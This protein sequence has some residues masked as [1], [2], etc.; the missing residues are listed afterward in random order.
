[1]RR[2]GILACVAVALMGIV[3]GV[4]WTGLQASERWWPVTWLAWAPVGAVILWKRSGNGVGRTL[5]A[6]GTSWGLSFIGLTAAIM[7]SSAQVMAWGEFISDLLGVVPWLG[8]VWLLLV[9]PSGRVLGRL[10]KVTAVGVL[11][12]SAYAV[13]SFMTSSAPMDTT[14]L[15]S[16]LAVPTLDPVTSWLVSD[17][18]FVI[19]L[20]LAVAAIVSLVIRWWTS[21]GVERHQF[22]WLL[23]GSC[24]YIAVLAI[25]QVATEDN[26]LMFVWIAAGAAIPVSIGVAVLRYRLYD[27]DRIVSRTVAYAVVVILLGA[28]FALGVVGMPNLVI[29]T[30]SAPPLVVAASTLAVAALFNPLRRRVLRWVDRRFNRSRYDAERVMDQFALSLRDQ[31]DP[32]GVLEGW[33]G[34]VSAAMQPDS[35]GVWVKS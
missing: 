33:K 32:S 7:A 26:S 30:G 5:L 10:E 13:L 29:G 16:P 14:G 11:G 17:S 6:I 34:V 22:R 27:I 15:Q 2:F 28:V 8:I 19:V 3:A 4:L 18:G 23:L 1:M 21:S 35:V 25:G 9:F 24:F 12:F 31:T 20:V